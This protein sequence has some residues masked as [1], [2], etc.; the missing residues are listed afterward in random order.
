M[1]YTD[2]LIIC[3]VNING[4]LK[5]FNTQFVEQLGNPLLRADSKTF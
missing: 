5:N 2:L 1:Y 3:N 4:Y